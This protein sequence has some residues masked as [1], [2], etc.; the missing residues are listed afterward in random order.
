MSQDARR[1]EE[2]STERRAQTLGLTYLDTSALTEKP[3][4]KDILANEELYKLR[5]IPVHVDRS[6]ILFGVISTDHRWPAP[7]L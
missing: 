3:L 4:F 1:D 7:A 2:R 5:V 6:N